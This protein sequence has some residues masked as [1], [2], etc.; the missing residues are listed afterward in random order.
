MSDQYVGEIRVFGGNYAPEG[1]AMCNGQLLPINGNEALFSLIGQTYGGDGVTNFAL[2]DLRGR[3]ALHMG[4]GTTGSIY[5]MGQVGGSETVTLTSAQLPAHTHAAQA[6]SAQ[7]TAA[8]PSN[9]FWAGST[10]N[11]YANTA[12]DGVMD[13]AALG[14]AGGNQAH[15]NMMPYL[16]LTFIIALE[17]IYP[18]HN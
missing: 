14:S 2:P 18:D 8:S 12:P 11:Q 5:S 6:Q 13:P 10:I 17:G 4:T 3:L 9:A 15:D 16:T 1:W 7:G